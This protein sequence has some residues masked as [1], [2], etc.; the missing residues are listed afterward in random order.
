MK[1]V[2]NCHHLQPPHPLHPQHL[3][4]AYSLPSIFSI[5]KLLGLSQAGRRDTKR[6]YPCGVFKMIIQSSNV[7]VLTEEPNT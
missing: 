6:S 4:T 1:K 5:H 2:F 7:Y 3:L